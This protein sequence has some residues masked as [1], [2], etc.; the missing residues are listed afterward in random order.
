MST[1]IILVCG[2]AGSGKDTFANLFA[3][4]TNAVCISQA[5]PMKRLAKQIFRFSD[6]QLWGPSEA[7]N[8]PDERFSD[9]DQMWLESFER[10]KY[11]G[12]KWVEEV[13]PDLS[14]ED[15]L[16]AFEQLKK[17]F[18][19]V[20]EQH[21]VR[22]LTCRYVLQTL[23]TQWGREFS[24]DM[25][26]RYAIHIAKK[27]LCGGYNYDR[28]QGILAD[29]SA[30]NQW[31]TINDGRFLNEIIGVQYVNGIT[32]KVVN[33]HPTTDAAVVE[34]AGVRG[35]KS[36]TELNSIPDHFFNIIL[37]NDKSRGLLS[38]ENNVAFIA[39][40]LINSTYRVF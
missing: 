7:R 11:Y 4:Y 21:V 30:V 27:L 12:F 18:G 28:A 6:H 25:W 13:L 31:V 34:A 39:R 35:H 14:K 17:W 24:P 40:R 36:E 10:L 32:I 15:H 8:A 2:A 22:V 38:L 3:K 23:G 26:N 29:Q 1:P 5:D 20:R 19:K 9:D 33:P 37:E 16:H